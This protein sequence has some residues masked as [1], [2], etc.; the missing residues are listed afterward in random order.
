MP[1][2]SKDIGRKT[3]EISDEI[4]DLSKEIIV[5]EKMSFPNTRIEYVKVYPHISKTIA[6]RCTKANHHVKLF[7]DND[8]IIE[9][10][11]ELWDVLDLETQKILLLHELLHIKVTENKK[12]E[13][14]LGLHDHDI[15]DFNRIISK[16]GVD[17]FNK[18]KILNSSVYDLEPAQEDY[19]SI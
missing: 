15:K 4:K 8:F 12:G 16:Y 17:W 13:K 6:G 5:S 1:I 19:F 2:N 3:Y 9:V 7:S 10:S 18:I 11:G 14:V